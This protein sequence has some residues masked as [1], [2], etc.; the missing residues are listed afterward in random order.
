[1]KKM[2]VI[3][4]IMFCIGVITSA[5]LAGYIYYNELKTYT[6]YDKQDLNNS[7]LDNVYIDS[8]IPIQIEQTQGNGYVEFSQTYVDLLGFAPQYQLNITTKGKDSYIKLIQKKEIGLWLGMQDNT[9]RL[10]IYLPQKAYETLRIH[11]E[12]GYFQHY[13][14]EYVLSLENIDIANLNIDIHAADIRLK[15][16]YDHVEVDM[17]RGSLEMQSDSPAELEVDGDIKT[18]LLG[19]YKNISLI[20]QNGNRVDINTSKPTYLKIRGNNLEIKARGQ[21][22]KIMI[23]GYQNMIDA[24]SDSICKLSIEGENNNITAN[25]A[26]KE[27]T[28]DTSSSEIDLQATVI[29]RYIKIFGEYLDTVSVTLPSNIPG[30]EVKYAVKDQYTKDDMDEAYYNEAYLSEMEKTIFSD[31]SVTQNVSPSGE[32]TYVFGDGSTPILFNCN[33]QFDLKVIDGGYSSQK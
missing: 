14:E 18:N 33:P 17:N 8:V 15:G 3:L 25:G 24:K 5:I 20:N 13:S 23:D 21:Y 10:T 32:V 19:E 4:S 31:Y 2:L 1:M 7:A 12:R 11:N 16:N 30:F 9:A 22:D 26:F 28:F 27:M 29:P 6:D